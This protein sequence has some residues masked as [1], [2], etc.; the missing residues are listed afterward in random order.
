MTGSDPGPHRLRQVVVVGASLAGVRTA[1]ALRRHGFDETLV[2]VGAESHY[3]PFDRPPLSK[4]VLA[5]KWEPERGR[6]RIGTDVGA[7]LLLGRRAVAL[8]L[9]RRRLTLDGGDEV[10]FDGLVLATGCS[11]RRVGGE[12]ASMQGVH[13]LRTIDDCLALRTELDRSPRVVVVGA[14]FIGS[15]VAATCRGRGLDV[16]IVEALPLPLLPVLGPE[17]GE[18]MAGLHRDHGTKLRLGLGVAR[19]EGRERVEEVVLSDGS[20]VAADVVVIGVGVAPETAWLDGSGLLLDNGVVCD[21]R[22]A[23][24]GAS[25][26]VAAG[27]VARWFNPLFGRLMRVEHWTNAVEQADVAARRLVAGADGTPPFAPAPYFWSDQYDA[28]VQF[29][30]TTGPEM[31]V[32]EGDVEQRKFVAAFGEAGRTVGVL[33]FSWPARLARYRRLVAAGAA[34]P[35]SSSDT[36][37]ASDGPGGAA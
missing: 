8:D 27:D 15:E 4:E 17:M 20:R 34:F 22:C 29:V 36:P 14:G 16:T 9:E 21:E 32:V 30:G 5:G 26:V 35:P 18:V 24:V 19:F 13:V 33:C 12:S 28:K 25:R 1:E 6:L 23:A 10:G 31:S 7:D 37:L 2:L 11:P 3:P